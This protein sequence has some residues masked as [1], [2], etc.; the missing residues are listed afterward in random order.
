MIELKLP[1]NGKVKLTS[2]YGY[3]LLNGEYNYH[4][5]IDLVGLNSS[6]IISPCDGIVA[7]STIIKDKNNKTWEWGNYVKIINENYEIFLC[8]MNE[9][10]VEVGQKV[11]TGDA[12][13]REGNTGY[14]FGNHCH[15]ELRIDGA[16]VDI[17]HYLNIKNVEGVYE[18]I[19][20]GNKTHEWS[21]KEVKFCI[22]SGILKGDSSYNPNYRL[23]ENITREEMCVMLY[24]LKEYL[25]WGT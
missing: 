14:S 23:N 21:E 20:E 10:Y 11:K 22:D 6:L 25:E 13:G 5:G 3:R 17:T 9:R 8:H 7:T 19:A 1:Y 4:S 24:R 2:P 16:I 18:N 12:I 15:F